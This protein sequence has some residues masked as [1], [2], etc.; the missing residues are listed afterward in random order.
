MF[1]H[2][3]EDEHETSK[4]AYHNKF[5]QRSENLTTRMSTIH[6]NN[7]LTDPFRF[8]DDEFLNKPP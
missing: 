8:Q 4:L 5:G 6:D 3:A 1:H 2:R 7:D